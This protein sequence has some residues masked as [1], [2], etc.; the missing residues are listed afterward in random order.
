MSADRWAVVPPNANQILIDI[1]RLLLE[2]LVATIALLVKEAHRLASSPTKQTGFKFQYE[3]SQS[4]H[5]F[6]QVNGSV[7]EL[8]FDWEDDQGQAKSTHENGQ[9]NL[10]LQLSA[11]LEMLQRERQEHGITKDKISDLQKQLASALDELQWKREDLLVA[12]AE[13]QCAKEMCMTSLSEA[14]REYQMLFSI[15]QEKASKDETTIVDLQNQVS[16][17]EARGVSEEPVSEIAAVAKLQGLEDITNA[18][19]D[20]EI[21]PVPSKPSWVSLF[22]EPEPIEGCPPHPFWDPRKGTSSL[23]TRD[24][25]AQKEQKISELKDK[26]SECYGQLVASRNGSGLRD[27]GFFPTFDPLNFDSDEEGESRKEKKARHY[28]APS[29]TKPLPECAFAL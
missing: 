28:S 25:I 12:R 20:D 4:N 11:A 6:P 21:W 7:K 10:K 16:E 23:S 1:G 26:L 18:Q 27:S 3:G 2:L 19:P 14:R 29:L 17:L 8:G 15:T 5:D 9:V 22:T 13:A 24:I